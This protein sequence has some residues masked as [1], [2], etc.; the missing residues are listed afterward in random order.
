MCTEFSRGRKPNIRGDVKFLFPKY[1]NSLNALLSS[2]EICTKINFP[3][4]KAHPI[5][6]EHRDYFF[7][8]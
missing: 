5:T 4:N 2:L 6:E 3:G 8:Y 7:L 1:L